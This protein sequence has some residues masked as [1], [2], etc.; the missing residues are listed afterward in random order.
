MDDIKET[1]F[2]E[3][4]ELLEELEEGLLLLKEGSCDDEQINAMF[5]AVHSIKGG[6]GAF[7]LTNLVSLSHKF[8]TV[9]DEV[10][11]KRID[12]TPDLIDLFLRSADAL[13]DLVAAARGGG[14]GDLPENKDLVERLQAFAGSVD[15]VANEDASGDEFAAAGF[16][17]VVLDFGDMA[18]TADQSPSYTVQFRPRMA[19]Y[20]NGNEPAILLRGLDDIGTVSA[21]C[22][23]SDVPNFDG[24]EPLNAY[25]SWQ[26]EVKTDGG[27]AAIDEVFEFALDD[28]ELNIENLPLPVTPGL[29]AD[30]ETMEK[31]ASI[32]TQFAKPN[33]LTDEVESVAL[34]EATLAERVSPEEDLPNTLGSVVPAATPQKAAPNKTA[35]VRVDLDRVDRLI[36]LVGELVINQAMLSENVVD[37]GLAKNTSVDTGLEELRQ[38]TREIQESV[39]AIRAQPLKSLFQRM[40][41]IVR[42][43][44]SATQKTVRL[45]TEGEGTEVD[46]TVIE[47]LAD[48]LTHM[49]RNAVDHGLESTRQRIEAGKSEE[50]VVTLRAAHRSG[51]VVIEISDDGAGIN[52]D[53]VR[54]IAINKGLVPGDVALTGAEIDNLLFMPGFSTAAEVSDLSG[55]G[56]GMDVVKRSIQALGG[57]ISINSSPGKGSTFSVSLPLTL[58]VLDG[59]I[60]DLAGQTIVVPLTS[61]VE[62]LKPRA[63]D[64]HEFSGGGHLLKVRGDFVPIIDVAAELKFADADSSG[65]KDKV[66]LHIESDDNARYALAV[67]RIQDQRQVVIKGLKDNYGEIPGIAAATILGD[68]R[69]ALILDA[70]SLVQTVASS[71]P[72]FKAT[73]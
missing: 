47:R 44:A 58:A 45:V 46:K 29:A 2:Q 50:G 20:S 69:I 9:L 22:D 52:R 4:E 19:L 25:L 48:P 24:F 70:D 51:R 12:V 15:D 55:R 67:D 8:E 35:T 18:N 3:C 28:C 60:V 13:T 37:A 6:A 36:N 64:V 68:G 57:R 7:A 23:A 62:T 1:F 42:E 5:R 16:V 30:L 72:E 39:M 71:D 66:F 41:R 10:R 14:D 53:R 33:E 40:S 65:Y 63:T 56:V 17:P 49:I 34:T 21:I 32:E 31:T 26:F 61:V 59:M 11:S 73:G 54:D 43:A 38:L 27:V